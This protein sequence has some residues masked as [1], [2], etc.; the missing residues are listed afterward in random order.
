MS[1]CFSRFK[2]CLQVHVLG[3]FIGTG[4]C[5]SCEI[6][7]SRSRWRLLI[8]QIFFLPQRE[9][10]EE[11]QDVEKTKGSFSGLISLCHYY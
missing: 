1:A 2:V 4:M 9:N 10:H 8:V 5:V 7:G 11:R 3:Q 6:A